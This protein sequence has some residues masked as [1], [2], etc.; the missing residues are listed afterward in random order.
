MDQLILPGLTGTVV[1]SRSLTQVQKDA[2][3]D[4]KH[5]DVGARGGYSVIVMFPLNIYWFI[6]AYWWQSFRSIRSNV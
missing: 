3:K 6:L 5:V 4:T 1:F 2:V